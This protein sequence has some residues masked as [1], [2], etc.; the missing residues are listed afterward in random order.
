MIDFMIDVTAVVTG[1]T[2]YGFIRRKIHERH[3]YTN[4]DESPWFKW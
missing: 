1:L 4:Y 2:V 3:Y